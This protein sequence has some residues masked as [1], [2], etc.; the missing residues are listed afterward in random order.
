MAEFIVF[1]Q[2]AGKVIVANKSRIKDE[3]KTSFTWWDRTLIILFHLV[4]PTL[5]GLLLGISL[6][7]SELSTILYLF[8]TLVVLMPMLLTDSVNKVKVK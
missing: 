8:I 7:I 5:V 3:F 1:K 6:Q 4:E 2:T